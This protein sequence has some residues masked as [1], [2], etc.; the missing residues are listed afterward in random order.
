MKY[1]LTL[2][3][4][5]TMSANAFVPRTDRL[6]N[7]IT[8]FPQKQ[9][10][11]LQDKNG[12]VFEMTPSCSLEKLAPGLRH[13]VKTTSKKVR[14]GSIIRIETHNEAF[15]KPFITRCEVLTINLVS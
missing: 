8:I 13:D 14:P 11:E 1:I 5:I 12:R 6:H 7:E 3:L 15:R 2:L 10:I 9:L 4:F